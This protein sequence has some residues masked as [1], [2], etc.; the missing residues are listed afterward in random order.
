MPAVEFQFQIP[1]VVCRAKNSILKGGLYQKNQYT[2]RLERNVMSG[3]HQKLF[4]KY[5]EQV[6]GRGGTPQANLLNGIIDI[7][8][9]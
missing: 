8:F 4:G 2:T 3:F 9:A 5:V 1:G 7:V 6:I